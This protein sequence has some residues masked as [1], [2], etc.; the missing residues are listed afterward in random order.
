METIEK[1]SGGPGSFPIGSPAQRLLALS[2]AILLLLIWTALVFLPAPKAMDG[3]MLV[4]VPAQ[5]GLFGVAQALQEAGAIRSRLAFVSLAL[6]RGSA[7]ALRAGEYELPRGASTWTVLR[8]V[9]SGKVK[10]R[11][12]TIPEGYGLADIAKLL[13]REGLVTEEE[14]LRA[15]VDKT[16]LQHLGV[17]GSSLEGYLFPDTYYFRKGQRA[18]DLLGRM[19]QQTRELLTP[20]LL[21]EAKSK[22]LSVHQLLTLASIVERE[23][24]LDEERPLIAAVFWN[25]LKA[26]MPLQADPT[27]A[28]VLG[29][30]GKVLSREDLAVDSPYNT[31]RY[32]GLPPGPIANPGKASIMAALRP[33]SVGY[34]YFVSLDDT[35]HLFSVSLAQHQEAIARA[36]SHRTRGTL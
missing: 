14:I 26:G 22:N 21:A 27:V 28:Y 7:R 12:V 31:Y 17:Q 30:N 6:L 1:S 24:K 23:A 9:E 15:S 16:L 32:P 3:P 19:V 13:A 4:E 5:S 29:K 8:L 36:R 2:A 35:H 20:E 11:V 18:E 10:P 33:A 25:R 34:L